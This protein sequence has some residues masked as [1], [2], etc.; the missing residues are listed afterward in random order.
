MSTSKITYNPFISIVETYETS[1]KLPYT[2]ELLKIPKPE[3]ADTELRN[4]IT[5]FKYTQW[6]SLHLEDTSDE[7]WRVDFPNDDESKHVY[8]NL[9]ELT[10]K[11]LTVFDLRHFG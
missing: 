11:E 9:F 4:M 2:T 3:F 1:N 8:S 10:T 7:N 5:E 6:T